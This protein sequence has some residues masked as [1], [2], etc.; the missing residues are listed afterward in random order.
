M[1]RLA[2]IRLLCALAAKYNLELNVHD[3]VT[4]FLTPAMDT[5]V[6]VTLPAAFNNDKNLQ[7]E[8]SQSCTVHRLLKGVP[9]IPQGSR[10]FNDYF[11]NIM[12]V[13]L[14]FSRLPGD[15]CIY[16]KPG[17]RIFIAI[18]VDDVLS[19]HPASE[20]DYMDSVFATLKKHVRLHQ[21]GPAQ[22][23][24]AFRINR[25][26]TKQALSLDQS[27]A[28]KALLVKTGMEDCHPA[29]TPVAT[30]MVFTKQDCPSDVE[31]ADMVE[32][33]A[34]YRSVL[35]SILYFSICTRPD[36]VFAVS[37]LCKY[38]HNPGIAHIKALKR[39]LR[40]LKGTQTR[41]L[42]YD[43]STKPPL[44]GAYGYYDAA[45]ADDVDTRRSTMAYLFLYEGCAISW[46]TKLHTY[47]TTSTNHS[48]YVASSKAAREA[49][50]LH[51]VLSELRAHEGPIHLFSD[52]AG[53]I[54][55][56]HNPIQ[57]HGANKHVDLADH[58]AR[59]Q[60]ERGFITITHVPTKLMIADVLTKAMSETEYVRLINH[61][62]SQAPLSGSPT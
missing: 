8:A 57:A 33:Q 36:I 60:V 3:C 21:G 58:Y 1:A 48:E 28:V 2:S 16:H 32:E 10:L 44:Q 54:A 41:C 25:D 29:T 42:V 34:W 38:M 23:Y 6:Y 31:R 40:Y 62:T 9:G 45:H 18:W 24:L 53:A 20:Q 5:E 12:T 59:E 19:A 27:D 17:Q 56:N 35:A 14:G 49:K 4:A 7:P 52:S 43:F 30:S 11:N 46:A 50:W 39:L 51:P 37:K 13:E 55:M 15:Y 22:D 47:V 26:R 61:F